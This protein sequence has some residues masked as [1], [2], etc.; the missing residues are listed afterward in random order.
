MAFRVAGLEKTERISILRKKYREEKDR[1]EWALLDSKGK[2]VLRWFGPQKPSKER[3]LK[4][5][6]RIQF[7]KHKG[8][9]DPDTSA[10]TFKSAPEYKSV[11]DFIQF[12]I[13]DEDDSFGFTD[14]QALNYRLQ[15]PTRELRNEL[16]SYGLKLRERPKAA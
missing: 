12:K 3:V 13:D 2:R 7:F 15:K 5:E 16:E 9:S 6:R 4:E 1:S 8:S 11:E 10:I 14:L